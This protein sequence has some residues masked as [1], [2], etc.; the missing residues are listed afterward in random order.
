M[1]AAAAQAP[2]H[3]PLRRL[4]VPHPRQRRRGRVEAS[5]TV[6][7]DRPDHPGR[8]EHGRPGPGDPRS[9]AAGAGLP[10]AFDRAP[11]GRR[12][13]PLPGSSTRGHRRA[14]GYPGRNGEVPI[15]LRDIC[16][17]RRSRGRGSERHARGGPGMNTRPDLE[18][19]VTDWLHDEVTTAGSDRVLAGALVRV[20]S[21]G[22]ERIPR[23]ERFPVMNGYAKLAIGLAAVMVVAV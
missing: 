10:A 12:P 19:I 22:Q 17:P 8:A 20:S 14:A 5:A 2:R 4:A 23:P 11:G 16:A 21:V 15:L 9:R 1:L 7:D 18:R 6:R 3:R 13:P